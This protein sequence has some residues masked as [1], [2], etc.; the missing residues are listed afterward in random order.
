MNAAI[1][2]I[3]TFKLRVKLI[4]E[5]FLR[6]LYHKLV[7]AD[8]LKHWNPFKKMDRCTWYLPSDNL[9]KIQITRTS[10]EQ[11][12]NINKIRFIYQIVSSIRVGLPKLSTLTR[13]CLEAIAISDWNDRTTS[14]KPRQKL[15]PITDKATPPEPRNLGNS[16]GA[17]RFVVCI[18]KKL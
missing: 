10:V 3:S 1:S 11:K 17:S 12:S 13:C 14:E 5:E 7:L 4:V 15:C 2:R 16:R 9:S 18:W 8:F 6:Y